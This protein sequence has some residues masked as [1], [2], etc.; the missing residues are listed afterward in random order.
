MKLQVENEFM[1]KNYSRQV[2]VSETCDG[3]LNAL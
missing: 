2:Y 3:L 1:K